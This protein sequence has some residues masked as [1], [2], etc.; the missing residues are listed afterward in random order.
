[1]QRKVTPHGL[2]FG[3][4]NVTLGEYKAKMINFGDG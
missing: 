2:V 4:L 3:A 1:M